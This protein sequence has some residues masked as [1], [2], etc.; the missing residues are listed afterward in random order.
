VK[1][2]PAPLTPLKPRKRPLSRKESRASKSRK[3][4]TPVEFL[5][6]PVA[7]LFHEA[8]RKYEELETETP[9]MSKASFYGLVAKKQ[10]YKPAKRM[11]GR[12]MFISW[13]FSYLLRH[14]R[15]L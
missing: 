15:D 11:T 9:F 1:V 7:T 12:C 10:K 3:I 8:K 2:T 4:T 6:K 5:E 14:V 13:D